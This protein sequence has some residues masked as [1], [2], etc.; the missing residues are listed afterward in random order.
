VL[1]TG[2]PN[3]NTCRGNAI[4]PKNVDDL[5]EHSEQLIE[6]A[7]RQNE[8]LEKRLHEFRQWLQQYKANEQRKR[9]A[10]IAGIGDYRSVK[11]ARELSTLCEAIRSRATAETRRDVGDD[12]SNTDEGPEKRPQPPRGAPDEHQARATDDRQD[13]ERLCSL[14]KD[15]K[16][17]IEHDI[18]QLNQENRRLRKELQILK[19]DRTDAQVMS[20][21][22]KTVTINIGSSDGLEPGGEL[23][24]IR[25]NTWV[26]D[27]IVTDDISPHKAVAQAELVQQGMTIRRGDRVLDLK[28]FLK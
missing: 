4:P 6:Q 26:A 24:V 10:G 14:I 2:S 5:I 17:A 12:E 22:G 18:E 13:L 1:Q 3:K 11:L 19:G 15:L 27:L 21:E 20:S 25:G 7:R 23:V 16:D 9:G 28:S 8:Q